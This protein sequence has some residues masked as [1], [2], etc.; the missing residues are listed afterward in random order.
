MSEPKKSKETSA[1]E[2]QLLHP[3]KDKHGFL[4]RAAGEK[5]IKPIPRA[6]PSHGVS[7][8]GKDNRHAHKYPSHQGKKMFIGGDDHEG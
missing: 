3:N 8:R 7:D 2:A 4:P 5:V 6:E 1:W